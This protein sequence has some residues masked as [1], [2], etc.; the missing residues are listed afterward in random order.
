MKHS[1][2]GVAVGMALLLTGVLG[3]C[4]GAAASKASPTSP[5]P[6]FVYQ[7]MISIKPRT[8]LPLV[9]PTF[10]PKTPAFVGSTNHDRYLTATDQP[11]GV[12]EGHYHVNV[13]VTP[14]LVAVNSPSLDG[15]ANP[16]AEVAAFGADCYGSPE[17]A[18]AT[19]AGWN[20]DE[21]FVPMAQDPYRVDHVG[22]GIQARVY[23][24]GAGVT[25]VQ[26]QQGP[27]TFE[28]NNS[29]NSALLAVAQQ[30]VRFVHSHPLPSTANAGLVVMN[31]SSD[32]TPPR[33]ASIT[34]LAQSVVMWTRGAVVYRVTTYTPL[35]VLQMTVSMRPFRV[36]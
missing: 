22:S 2:K 18:A 6:T 30:I 34:S 33:H 24:G 11:G 17:Q 4:G 3:G 26:W 10:V 5:F 8:T 23:S 7:E 14:T 31:F 28:V 35:N 20:A 29:A 1:T 9:A 36:P 15:M 21:G 32:L 13:F 12:L 27:W 16:G 19:L 25:S